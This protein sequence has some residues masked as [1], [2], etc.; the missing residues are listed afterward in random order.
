MQTSARW[1]PRYGHGPAV[2]TR[3]QTQICG[4]R[5]LP[6]GNQA[7]LCI[8]AASSGD[9]SHGSGHGSKGKEVDGQE[10]VLQALYTRC[11]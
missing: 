8:L 4:C 7:L 11:T 5:L 9:F 6:A 10:V 1:Y 3:I 2:Y